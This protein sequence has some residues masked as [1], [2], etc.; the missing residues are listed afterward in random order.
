MGFGLVQE[1]ALAC[2]VPSTICA[3]STVT[4]LPN[5]SPPYTGES[6]GDEIPYYIVCNL[7]L[8]G[9]S[10]IGCASS[11]CTFPSVAPPNM[12]SNSTSVPGPATS[13]GSKILADSQVLIEKIP[14]VGTNFSLYYQSQRV[15]GNTTWYEANIPMTG[16]SIS[17]SLS[18]IDLT[19]TIGTRIITYSDTSPA[20]NQS[21]NLTWDG[22]DGSGSP[23]VGSVSSNASVLETDPGYTGYWF[24]DSYGYIGSPQ[25]FGFTYINWVGLGGW[26]VGIHHSYDPVRLTLYTGDGGT[27][28]TGYQAS[29]SNSLV[30]SQDGSEVYVFDSS[31]RHINTL[32]GLLGAT[33]YTFAYNGSGQLSTITDAYS[34]VTTFNYTSGNLTSISAPYGQSTSVT[35]ASVSGTYYLSS[36]SNPNSETYNMTYYT[37]GLLNTFEKPSGV[38]STMTY[39][40]DGLLLTDSSSAGSS[41]TLSRSVSSPNWTISESSAMSRS[42]SHAILDSG[43]NQYYR[44]DTDPASYSSV[45]DYS[46]GSSYTASTDI[47]GHGRTVYTSLMFDLGMPNL[48]L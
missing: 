37:G 47:L 25:Y 20:I 23:V 34:N 27:Y 40:S 24:A 8:P 36:V 14:I 19:V 42:S 13:C 4:F 7:G 10:E 9:E 21:Y 18:Q 22:K 28:P 46:Q 44:T 32:T 31:W 3:G 48:R 16:S 11:F 35:T 6:C 12:N 5:N 33:K 43:L 38:T 1:S 29:G 41:D 2:V 26:D 45:Y 17:G 39:S 30:L 15:P